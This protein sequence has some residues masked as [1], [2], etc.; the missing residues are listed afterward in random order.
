VIN[1]DNL[2]MH[3][4]TKILLFCFVLALPGEVIAQYSYPLHIRCVDKEP[5]I[6]Q[7]LGIETAFATRLSCIEYVTKLPAIL[8][9]KG[10]VTASID[11]IRFDTASANMVLYVG[12]VYK[13]AHL[14][15]D[16]VEPALL[17]AVG[18]NAKLFTGKP[19][20]FTQVRGWQGKLL[21][22][23]ENNGYPFA[24]VYL[25]SLMLEQD[26]VNAMLKVEKGPVYK[27][28]SIRVYGN[29]K[30]SN[31]F[32]QRYL[33]IPNGSIYNKEKLL[34]ISKKIMELGYL[35]EERPSDLSLLGTGAVLNLYLKTKRN[36]Q[37]NVLVGFLPNNDQL[38]SK[39]L[40]IT[41]E[42]NINLRNQLGAG[43]TFGFNWQQL[44]VKSPRLNIIYQHPF[45]FNSP[46]G[47]DF[48]F[49]IFKKDSTFLNINLQLGAR[50]L[51]NANQTA[52]LFLQRFQTVI[53]QGA[54]NA[55]FIIQN[56]RLPDVADVSALN[57][58]VDYEINK[59]N[60]RLNPRSGYETRIVVA[61]GTKE[62][63]KNNEI[64]E[65][66]DPGDPAFDFETLYDTVKLKTYQFRVQG[67][68]AKFFPLGKQGTFKMGIQGGLLQ[69][70]NIFR[71]ELFQVG[72]YKLLRGFDEE[73]QY[74][75]QYAIATIEYR[76]LFGN[77]YF[78]AFADG[79]WAG[80][81]SRISKSS[82]S[83]IG[84]GVGLTLETRNSL[85]TIAWAI[86]QRDDVPFNLRQSK[87][88]LGF[89]NFF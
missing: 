24:K 22:Y 72:G 35:Q 51:I 60:Y 75:S 25:D 76:Y 32:L 31:F 50:Y 85:F 59:T 28:D 41:G 9:A 54:I 82:H 39:K 36:S 62:I 6:I 69:S 88:H 8:Q 40:L 79:G 17:S 1:F 33:D 86:G 21:D 55:P 18:W 66:K 80:N 13:W 12:P 14:R 70:D 78:F 43:E 48:A 56:R 49:D 23:L 74:V 81:T 61:A 67:N 27:I 47:L 16:S 19:M 57:I 7:E 10:Y 38:S 45:L 30:I 64:L 34:R 29:V 65:L 2:L 71:N 63:K 42:A 83:Y 4:F 44:Q 46:I 20:D 53:S 26:S 5:S 15:T 3:S 68:A 52:K 87:I 84:T 11:S 73:S 77:S 89:V 58:G 37:V